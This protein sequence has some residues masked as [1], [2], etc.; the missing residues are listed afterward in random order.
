MRGTHGLS[1]KGS[2]SNS[3]YV[4]PTAFQAPAWVLCA[5]LLLAKE[6]ARPLGIKEW[7]VRSFQG[8]EVDGMTT[9]E[10]KLS[11][12]DGPIPAKAVLGGGR[13]MG[14]PR[15]CAHT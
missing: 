11:C 15:C 6:V 3:S 10:S 12:T 4:S 8:D 14:G 9:S 7:E 2:S 5:F 1:Q 13:G